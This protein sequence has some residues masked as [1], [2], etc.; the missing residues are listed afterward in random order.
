MTKTKR[1]P[2]VRPET[3]SIRWTEE[4]WLL[5]ERLQKATG[6]ISVTELARQGL[7]ALAKK[8]GL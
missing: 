2:V 8:E 6:T 1:K 5:I 4:D 3:S 7:R